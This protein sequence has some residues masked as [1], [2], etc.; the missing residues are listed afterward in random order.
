MVTLGRNDPCHC[1]SGKKYKKCHLAKDAEAERKALE[2]A[3][4]KPTGEA[5][6]KSSGAGAKPAA[7]QAE[8]SWLKKILGKG[9]FFRP[10]SRHKTQGGGSGG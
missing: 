10:P 7:P 1:G 3:A 6:A 9:G 8:K 4:F 2:K 5:P